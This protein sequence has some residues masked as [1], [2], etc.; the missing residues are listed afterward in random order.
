MATV[1]D[2]LLVTLG[3]DASG[4]KS[5][6]DEV[7][8]QQS[9]LAKLLKQD[10]KERT[11]LDKKAQHAQKKRAD[12]FEKQGKKAA[13]TFGKIR[14]H[15]LGLI[16]VLA[17]GVGMAGFAKATIGQSANLGRLSHNLGMSIKDLQAWG[18][19]AKAVGGS[20]QGAQNLLGSMTESV[21][22]FR[23]NG[24]ESPQ[25]AAML[26]YGIDVHRTGTGQLMAVSKYLS[27][28]YKSDPALAMTRASEMGIDDNLFNLIKHYNKLQKLL[29][30]GRKIA[31]FS[32]GDAQ[33]AEAM[34]RWWAGFTTQIQKVA[35]SVFYA[36]LP[37]I[38][39]LQA[40]MSVWASWLIAHR[41]QIVGWVEKFARELVTLAKELNKGA[42][43]VGGW[44]NVLIALAAIKVLSMVGPLLSLA[45]ALARVGGGLGEIAGGGSALAIL[46]KLGLLAGAGVAGYEAGKHIVNPAINAGVKWAT[47]GKD[48]SFGQWLFNATHDPEYY[49]QL[50]AAHQNLIPIN[51]NNPGDLRRWG[52]TPVVGGFARFSSPA[53]GLT[54]MAENLKAYQRQGKDTVA[55]I[56]STWAPAADH[57]DTRAYINLTAQ[58]LGVKPDEKLNLNDPKTLALLMAAIAAQES[59]GNYYN[60]ATIRAVAAVAA[61]G[62]HIGAKS[63]APALR[64][65]SVT[66]NTST[67]EA[68]VGQVVINTMTQ[69]P[70]Q[71]GRLVSSAIQRYLGADQ[72]NSAFQ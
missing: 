45:S 29:A 44:R 27:N 18:Y 19:A 25:M 63:S 40:Q 13:E 26:K 58:R 22:N 41:T 28:L 52:S 34:Q 32:R 71:H 35:T 21:Q 12:A 67:A 64:A 43:A 14:E 37:A 49:A 11:E 36:F 48:T 62:R 47:N 8:K 1:I 56:I 59:G 31:P 51:H 70:Y 42:Q 17:G 65:A 39:Q 4:Y 57:N 61:Q 16:A 9:K 60:P 15:A 46:G 24:I 2:A 23:K 38:K 66:H 10:S 68:H 72:L 3:L 7:A 30:E 6:T 5:G 55:K 33:Q 20:A 69:D 54:A 50:R 53:A